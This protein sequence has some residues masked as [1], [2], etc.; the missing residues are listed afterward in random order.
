MAPRSKDF[1]N[2]E[3]FEQAISEAIAFKIKNNCSIRAAARYF[4]L[5]RETLS[6]RL[7]GADSLQIKA[8]KALKLSRQQEAKIIDQIKLFKANSVPF[9]YRKLGRLVA[10]I[11]DLSR[12]PTL[13]GCY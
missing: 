10:Y 7:R 3:Q 11:I 13:L 9:T 5:N 6:W 4:G 1:I 2:Q 8:E 12:S